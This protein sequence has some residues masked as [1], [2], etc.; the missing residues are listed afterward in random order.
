M[1]DTIV[2]GKDQDQRCSR[3]RR[4]WPPSRGRSASTSS[5]EST[6]IFNDARP[7]HLEQGVKVIISAPAKDE[8]ITIVIGVNDDKYDGN[9]NVISNA[10]CTTNCLAR[11]PR[12]STT[13]SASCV[14]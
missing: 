10:S 11:S 12:C 3:S 2:N 6:G 13:S 1:R 7:G 14:V 8:D 4:A 9:Q 5:S